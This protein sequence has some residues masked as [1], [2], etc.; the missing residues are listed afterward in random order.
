M[1]THD[2]LAA[3]DDLVALPFPEESRLEDDLSSGPGHHL[4]VLEASRDFWDADL[5]VVEEAYEEIETSLRGL[6]AAL[7]ARWGDPRPVDLGPYLEGEGP[8]P[9]SALS[10]VAGSMLVW[11]RPGTD[12]WLALAIGQADREF[13]VELIAAVGTTP[14][15]APPTGPA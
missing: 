14:L 15:A 3:V 1:T 7:S 12:R 2:H 4:R 6:A 11:Q 5:D 9:M 13:P 8:E 10:M